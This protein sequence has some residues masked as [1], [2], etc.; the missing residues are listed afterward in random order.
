[1]PDG[2][3]SNDTSATSLA[4]TDIFP[5][6]QSSTNKKCA[7]ST[8][9]N[10]IRDGD[11]DRWRELT[12]L[13]TKGA[14]TETFD[15][16]DTSQVAVGMPVKYVNGGT[17]YYGII[18]SI[19]ASTNFKI[20]GAPIPG[21]PTSL[22]VGR[23]EMVHRFRLFVSG[24]YAVGTTLL[25]TGA[26]YSKWL[27][28]AAYLCGFKAVAGTVTGG[29]SKI[30]VYIGADLVSTAN[31]NNGPQLAVAGTW[32]DNGVA[33]DATKYDITYDDVLEVKCTTNGG[34]NLNIELAFVMP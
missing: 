14:D 13:P 24:A 32:V 20:V 22:K 28:P 33:V 30:N 27:G 29:D 26:Q 6:V 7:F 12:T 23:P 3:I 4:T 5:I 9:F 25:A 8:L 21:N 18:K 16:A 34:S 11:Y 10:A 31:T 17:T 15:T 2:K 19:T 1:M